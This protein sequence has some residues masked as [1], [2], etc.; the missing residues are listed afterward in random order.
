M[1]T[2]ALE[3]HFTTQ[4]LIDAPAENP[5]FDL[6]GFGPLAARIRDLDSGRIAEMEDAVLVANVV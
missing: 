1:R 2:I 5:L 3:E 4:A 6:R